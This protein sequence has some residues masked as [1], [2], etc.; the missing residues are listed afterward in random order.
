MR[1]PTPLLHHC[2][3]P[4]IW[5][6]NKTGGHSDDCGDDDCDDYNDV[7]DDSDD[8]N[9]E[10]HPHVKVGNASLRSADKRN[11]CTGFSYQI[12]YIFIPYCSIC[13]QCFPLEVMQLLKLI[14]TELVVIITV[15]QII[16]VPQ[17]IIVTRI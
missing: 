12:Q 5:Q 14:N 6:L 8:V 16:I 10:N 2:S 15:T 4:I 17:I 13:S 11:L 3:N 9:D 1:L 7:D